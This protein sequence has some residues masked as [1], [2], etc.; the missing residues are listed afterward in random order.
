MAQ[1]TNL[2]VSPYFDDFDS[3]K[4]FYR[5][6]FNPGRPVQTRELNNIQSILQNQIESFGSHIFK[7]GSVVIPGNVTYDSQF[8]AVKLNSTSLGVNISNYIEQYVGK[9]IE[10]QISGITAIVQKVEIPNNTNDLEYITIYVKYLDSDNNFTIN[11]FTDGESLISTESILYGTTTIF[12][13]TPFATLISS[14]STSTGSAASINDGVYF[15]RGSF[16]A[17]TKE[18][19]I[20]DYYSNI[21]TYRIGLKVSEEIITAKEDPSLYDNAKG[22]TNYAAPGA[23][24]FK[25]SLSLTKKSIDSVETDTDFIELLRVENGEIKKVSTKTQYSLIRDYLA[26]R[27][28]DESGNYSI[29]PFKIS[30]HNSLNNRLGN[31][32]LFL[33]N[34][35]T[36]AGNT[37]SDDL[38]CIKLS[39]GKSY[40]KGYDIEK[41]NTTILD[42][43]KPRTTQKVENVS[44]PFEMGNLLR[45]NNVTGSP[46]QNLPVELHSVRRSASGTPSSSTKIG[47]ARVYNFRV[48]DAAYKD[49]TTN[50]DLYL[51]DIQTYTVLTLNQPLSSSELPTTSFVKGKSSGASG[52]AVS[53]GNNTTTVTLTQT[54]GTFIKGE[55]IYINGIEL[56]SRS[57]VNIDVYD[58][59]DIK[60]IYQSTSVSLFGAPFIGDSVLTKNLPIGFNA[61]D[62]ININSSGTVTCP[63]KFFNS[64]K[65]GSIIRY[66]PSSGSLEKYNRVSSVS[67]TGSSM[68]LVSV[69]NVNGICDGSVGV[70]TNISFSIGYPTIRNN[71]KGF[72]YAELPNSNI[73]SV[74]LNDSILTFCA[75]STSSKSSNSPIVLSVSDFPLPSGISTALFQ[76]FDEER[77]SVHY[78]DGTTESLTPDKFSLIN[79]QVTLS[80]LTPGKTTSAINATFIKNGVQSKQKQ[81]N[82]SQTINVI[83]SKYPESGTGISTSVNDGLIYN[84][85]YGLRVQDEEICLNYPDV[86][87]VL[88]IYESLDTNNPILDSLSFSVTLNVGTNALIGE[89]IT[90]SESGCIARIVTKFGNSVGI[91]YLNSNRFLNNENVKF[92][93]SNIIGEIDTLTLGSYTDITNRFKLEKGQ[94]GQYYDYSK[95][96]RAE[97]ETSPSKRLLIIFDYYNV[98][99]TDNGD[100]FTA[101]SYKKEQFAENVPLLGSNN[102]RATDTLDFRPIV[103]VF[104]SIASSPFHFTNRNFDSS[105]K[106]NLTS[107]ESSIVSYDY[108]VGRIDKIYLDKNG[109]FIYLK[110]L[111]TLDPKSPI[112]T[113]D[114]MELATIT[115][116]P[117]LYNVKNASIS[118]VDNRRYT[119]RDIGSI[120]NRVQNLERVTSLSLLELSTQTLQIQD[121]EGFNRFKTGF[122]VDDFKNYERINSNLSL[123]EVDSDSQE[124]TPIVSRNSLK[125]YLAPQLSIIDEEIDLSSNYN[126]VDSNVQK[127]GT[128]V[129]LK[130]ESKKWIEQPLATQVENV[131]P[132]HVVSYTGSVKLSPNRD[133][134]VRT[135]QLP[136]KSIS[137]TNNLLLERDQVL[138]EERTNVVNVA[139]VER[140]GEVEVSSP[141]LSASQNISESTNRTTTTSSVTNLTQ[142][143]PEEFMRSRNTEF[144]ISNLKPYTQYYQFLD[145][146]GSVDFVPK[147]VEISS[148]SSLNDFGSSSTFNV[149]EKVLGYDAN[150]NLII[151]FRV[152]A[153]NHKS[154]S[155]NL[156]STVFDTNPYNKNEN[157]S[158]GYSPSSKVLNVDTYSLSEEAQGLYSGFLVKGAKLVGQS[159][160][161]IAYVKDLRLISDNYG[162]LIGTFY[163]RDPHTSPPPNVRINTGNK[164]YKITSSPT[165]ETAAAGSTTISSGETNYISVGTIEFYE[166]TIT[167]TTNVTT[168]RTRTTTLT[169]TTTVTNY[170]DPLAQS[171]SVGGSQTRNDDENG[172]FLTSVDLYF[173]KKDSGTNP[174]TVQIRTV[175][176]GTPTR[177]ILGNS[178]TLRPDQINT[179]E[180]SSVA[181][182]VTFDYPV[183]LDPGLEYCIVLLA[184]ES[185]EYE[186]FIAEMGKKTI[187]SANLPDSES[188]VYTQ[189]FALGSLFKS[190]NGSIWTANQYQDM[191]FRLYRAEFISDTPSTVYFYNPSLDR[192]NGYV[193]NLQTN[194]ITVIPRKLKVGITTITDSNL[195]QIFNNGRKISEGGVSS[196]TYNYGYV[197]GTGCSVS[198]VGITTGGFNYVTSSPVSTYNI[199]GNGSGLTLNI[200]ASGG[201]ITNAT[202]A[203]PGNGYAIGDIVGIVT[204]SVTSSSG[205]DA[206]ITITGNNNGI[207]TLYLSNV[208]GNSFTSGKN[209]VYYDSSNTAISL[210][211]TTIANS[212]PIGSIYDGNFIRVNHFNHGMY[213]KNNKV[214][215]SGVFS[216]VLPTTLTQPIITSSTTISVAST[217]NFATFEGKSVG[218]LNPG[219]IIVGNE[220][221]KYESVNVNSLTAIS[222]AQDYTIAIPHNVGDQV[223]KY[224]FEGVS[225]RRINNTHDISDVGLDIDSYYIE[226]DRT[227]NGVNRSTDGTPTEHPQLSFS[228]ELTGGGSDVFA[229]ENIQYD[230][231][232]PFYDLITPSPL[233]SVTAKIRS[234]SGTS[235][236]GNEKS[237]DDLGYEDIQLNTLNRLYSSRIVCSK[238]NEEAY[239]TALPRKKSFTT[240]LTLYSS[241][242]YLS[243]QIFL[244]GSFTDF[245]SNRI[246]SPVSDYALD[247]RVNSIFNDPHVAI[248]ISNTVLL[249]QSATSLKVILS[250]YRHASA[251]FRVLYKLIRPDSSEVEQVFELFPGYDNLTIDNNNDGYLDVVDSKNNNGLPDTLVRESKANEF[252]EYEFSANNLGS[253]TG[254][255]IKI[256]MTTTNQA[257]PPR[258]KDLRTIALA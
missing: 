26:Q 198:S 168:T 189:Q 61:S 91:I 58:A 165:N 158:D 37:P 159:S 161:A 96:I 41:T 86:S 247:G 205:R 35:K 233:T 190:Q 75:Q 249:S 170:Y 123:I 149:G 230:A 17:I 33:E 182:K 252:L 112:K 134:W 147:L 211:S 221:I 195:V 105:I 48:T 217:A 120:E 113:N 202:I 39:P 196:K 201:L 115:L 103:P 178:V 31:D 254:Y 22:F 18:T 173:Y 216:N 150:N 235:V 185:V 193:K 199:N 156:P 77:Y 11:P 241:N 95:I 93:E 59:S 203:N 146:N 5:V 51:Y 71:E 220:I 64:I 175:E 166:T 257:Y 135:I 160:G 231:L 40:V 122:F 191:K 107:N 218:N 13:G 174:L 232:I 148:N 101:L 63:G 245:H 126:L 229:S 132:F 108:Y 119:M 90:G 3:E 45:I 60:Q 110:G 226:F 84:P 94:K 73:S 128:T 118:L 98:P 180:D 2:N 92:N 133:N 68:T 145:G 25:I 250:A 153:S 87:K 1:K 258:I 19:I 9:K 172:I 99:Q 7:E 142:T 208:Q 131:N 248:Y 121:S 21:P 179:S 212:T 80:N 255:T 204:S 50:W 97:G 177:T 246:N 6:L 16:V 62:T 207:D 102:I 53:A 15:V 223:Y 114:V 34:Q 163:I 52:F 4:N 194:P 20:L 65:P 219:Y 169:N 72:L 104:S 183:Y 82:R 213:S 141:Q 186:V 206:R 236:S 209:L 155:Y 237:F 129:T 242:K 228:S 167:N 43:E 85:Y 239:L 23:D 89:N 143:S 78:S 224:E 46:K 55:Q 144:S 171:F 8:F 109:D 210:A 157:I 49:E 10:G 124:L 106:F 74:D 127:T 197:F 38:M 192:S 138:F 187:Q 253:F 238:P 256:V 181:T 200:T 81:F 111:S 152:A 28:F 69:A 137:V 244:D 32:G 47:D 14:E 214:S 151:S 29:T 251:D 24:R 188:V 83:Y 70:A 234:V 57:I 164:T 12:S 225:L 139:N 240:A 176:L 79:N 162:D 76:S 243:P 88:A 215:I 184:P 100:V 125:N 140:R 66:Q 227:T 117:Y 116:P 222:R 42:V 30:L 36:E 27:T 136:N 56:Y 67:S 130:Y 154:G 44:I 54:S